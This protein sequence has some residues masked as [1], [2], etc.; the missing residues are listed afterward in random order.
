LPVKLLKNILNLYKAMASHNV[1]IR[2]LVCLPVLVGSIMRVVDKPVSDM[3]GSQVCTESSGREVY[4]Y[5]F[6]D[7][8][9]Y[10]QTQT[11]TV[12]ASELW[13]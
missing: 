10:P 3:I 2:R 5:I 4:T 12:P 7:C 1:P 8:Y 6:Q 9:D 13:W 11:G